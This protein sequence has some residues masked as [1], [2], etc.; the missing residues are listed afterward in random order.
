MGFLGDSFKQERKEVKN[1]EDARKAGL[2]VAHIYIT[3][4]RMA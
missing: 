3:L 4:E 1:G 2:L